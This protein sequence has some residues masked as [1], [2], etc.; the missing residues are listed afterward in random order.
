[1]HNDRG[2]VLS[3]W[4]TAFPLAG[5]VAHGRRGEVTAFLDWM[6]REGFTGGRILSCWGYTGNHALRFTPAEGLA[7]M[8]ETLQL[9]RDRGLYGMPVGVVDSTKYDEE[10]DQAW[11]IDWP[12]HLARLGDICY[13]GGMPMEGGQEIPHETQHDD[14]GAWVTN[15]R[16]P[17]DVLYCEASVHAANDC[18]K[19]FADGAFICSHVKRN[20]DQIER[21]NLVA[22]TFYPFNKP[23]IS[24][25]PQKDLQPAVWYEV[26]RTCRAREMGLAFHGAAVLYGQVPTGTELEGAR[27]MLRGLKGQ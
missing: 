21:H 23:Y 8:A 24:M 6:A 7:A 20:V 9:F 4:V 22:D 2:P 10:G 26:G 3:A 1:M 12:G 14:A 25:E 16:P 15:Y 13:R 5:M 11:N 27:Q 17:P 18:S 19:D